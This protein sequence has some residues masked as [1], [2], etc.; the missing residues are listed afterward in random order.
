[1]WT[2]RSLEFS[3]KPWSAAVGTCFQ[4]D[5]RGRCAVVLVLA[6]SRLRHNLVRLRHHRDELVVDRTTAPVAAA[7]VVAI[8]VADR[9]ARVE[10]GASEPL[11]LVV[12]AAAQHQVGERPVRRGRGGVPLSEDAHAH[13]QRRR[14]RHD[15]LVQTAALHDRVAEVRQRC[16]RA[17]MVAVAPDGRVRRAASG[18]RRALEQRQAVPDGA[19]TAQA[20][21]RHRV[22]LQLV[23]NEPVRQVVAADD[24]A[25]IVR[26]S[27]STLK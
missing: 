23:A 7:A 11:R 21:H 2:R 19:S 17:R 15:R 4:L 12:L 5:V 6:V 18:R 25:D 14:H 27:N 24:S 20:V 10:R 22:S 9:R 26:Y 16:G 3:S 8:V 1:V 13:R